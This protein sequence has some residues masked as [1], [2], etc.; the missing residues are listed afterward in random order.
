[1]ADHRAE[2]ILAAVQAAVTGLATTGANVD[3][4]RDAE[5]PEAS[6]PALRV[7]MGGDDIGDPW[8]QALLDSELEVGVMAKVFDSATNVETLLNRIRKE[9]NVAIEADYTLGLSFVQIVNELGASKP[10]ISE[11]LAKPAATIDFYYRV[12]YRRSRGDPSA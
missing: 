11:A 4:G 8:A 6:T 10:L 12:R 9:V 5:I 2:Q 3:R 1:M 7:Y